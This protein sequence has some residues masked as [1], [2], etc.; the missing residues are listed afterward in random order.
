[1]EPSRLLVYCRA[2]FER[3]CAQ[4]ITA[5]AAQMG[6]EGY[7]RAR[8]ESAFA[9]FTANDDA[10]GADLA[11][12]VE[13]RS[14]VFAR[15]AVRAGDLITLR[16]GDRVTPIVEA[17][18]S[19]GTRFT[20][21]FVEMPDTNDGKAL[22]TLTRPLTPHL[23]KALRNAGIDFD[24]DAAR[25]R[26][27]VFFVGGLACHVGTSDTRTASAWPMGIA[28]LRMPAGAPSRSTLKLA[29]AFQEFLDERSMKTLGPGATAV[30]LGASPGGWTWQ[31]V[32]RGVAVTAVDNGAMDPE[33]MDSGLVKHRRT[34]G[35]SFRPAAPVDWMVCDIVESPSR[36]ARLA[37][38]W[39][40][41]GWCRESLFN[42]KLPMKKR[43]E[44][45]LRARGIIDEALGGD[46]YFLRM[47]QLYHDREEVTAYLARR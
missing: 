23:E 22:A 10:M 35:L 29:E 16:E 2:G 44:E 13:L 38:R 25:D 39:I 18:R 27:H 5:V 12:H 4:E 19:L 30:D 33:L 8:P 43:W 40:A 9:L 20:E 45:V 32:R 3:E 15:Q 6:V 31:L 1:M 28:R 47:K 17:A 41:E 42:L 46:G 21:L 37:A 14:L 7:V 34:D 36:V 26:L 24:D 11:K